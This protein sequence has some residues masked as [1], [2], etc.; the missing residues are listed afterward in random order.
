M[1]CIPYRLIPYQVV[2][3]VLVCEALGPLCLGLGLLA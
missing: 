1:E 2:W 3:T